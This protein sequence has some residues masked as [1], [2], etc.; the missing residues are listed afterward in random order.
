MCLTQRII[1]LLKGPNYKTIETTREIQILATAYANRLL[2]LNWLVTGCHLE[3]ALN[4][5]KEA[6]AAA[7]AKGLLELKKRKFRL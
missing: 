4:I 3:L 7:A 5:L 1:N 6:D 2:R